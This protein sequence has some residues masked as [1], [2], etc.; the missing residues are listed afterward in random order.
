MPAQAGFLL[1]HSSCSR[2]ESRHERCATLESRWGS[3]TIG[4][5]YAAGTTRRRRRHTGQFSAAL[6]SCAR[7]PVRTNPLKLLTTNVARVG[8]SHP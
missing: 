7:S 6:S 1:P 3:P 4:S 2:F 5:L 8:M